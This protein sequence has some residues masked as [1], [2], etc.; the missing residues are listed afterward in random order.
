MVEGGHVYFRGGGTI[1]GPLTV[2]TGTILE[3]DGPLAYE[4]DSASSI[5]GAGTVAVAGTV[6]TED[7]ML[8]S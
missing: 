2:A 7:G 8:R 1:G 5:S 6:M 4:F 3:L